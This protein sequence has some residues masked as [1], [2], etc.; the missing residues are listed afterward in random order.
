[1]HNLTQT[2][3][4]LDIF[5]AFSIFQYFAMRKIFLITKQMEESEEN[6]PFSFHSNIQLLLHIQNSS[7]ILENP[8]VTGE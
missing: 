8:F 1:M 5:V 3:Y 2:K 6:F 7:S 4:H